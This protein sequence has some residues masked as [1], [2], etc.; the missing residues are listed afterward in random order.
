MSLARK[1][2]IIGA[3]I[4]VAA[5]GVAVAGTSDGQG[6]QKSGLFVNHG[7]N[8]SR[9]VSGGS[10]VHGFAILN[11]PG[12]VG[13]I[14]K[15]NGEVSLKRGP[16][17][18]TFVVQL[19]DSSG[20]CTPEGTLTTNHVGNG[21]AHIDTTGLPAGTYYVVLRD[22]LMREQFASNPVPLI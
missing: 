9:C 12:K 16:A 4:T 11:A 15:I 14:N 13:S 19:A 21:N 20:R 8:R 3:G 5:A 22:S 10:A 7:T 17:N 6:A 2:M 1:A 18:S